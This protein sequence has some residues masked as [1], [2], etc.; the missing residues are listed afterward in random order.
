MRGRGLLLGCVVASVIYGEPLTEQGAGDAQAEW[1]RAEISEKPSASTRQAEPPLK[2]DRKVQRRIED[3]SQVLRVF[4]VLRSQPHREVLERYEGP[5]RW[6][7]EMLEARYK[8]AAGQLIPLAAEIEQTRADWERAALAVRQAAFREI[9]SLIAP[10]QEAV[11]RLIVRLGGRNVRRYTAI[12]AIAAEVPAHVID[13]LAADPAVIEIGLIEP[14]RPHL[15]VS[16]PAL[17]APVFW[18]AGYTGAGESVAVMDTGVRTTDPA[19][20]GQTIAS[21]VFIDSGKQN[22]CFDDDVNS[23]EDKVGHGTHVAG[24]IA[25]R[26][27][28]A[29]TSCL[30]VARGLS[31]LYNLKIAYRDKCSGRAAGVGEVEALNWAV[32]HIPHVKIFNYSFGSD[33]QVDDDIL[34]RIFDYFADTYDLTITVSAGNDGWQFLSWSDV[35][36]V[37]SPGIAARG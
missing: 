3:G 18:N 1:T 24:I 33:T 30:G 36:E 8:R 21:Q 11:E 14:Q 23:P 17:G 19:F 34:S 7:L 31:N 20:A 22:S 35:K 12:N 2:V 9:A 13:R 6:R 28:T 25:S 32:Q 15:T 5:A 4:V 16:V 37:N 29:C 26:G 10:E 27:A